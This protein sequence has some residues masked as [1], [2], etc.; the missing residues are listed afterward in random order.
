MR[1][2]EL[3][4]GDRATVLDDCWPV[5]DAGARGAEGIHDGSRELNPDEFAY[6]V[7]AVPGTATEM[8]VPLRVRVGAVVRGRFEDP[9]LQERLEL[10]LNGR[11]DSSFD[12]GILGSGRADVGRG[13]QQALEGRAA[14]DVGERVVGHASTDS[15]EDE[16]APTRVRVPDLRALRLVPGLLLRSPTA[17]DWALASCDRRDRHGGSSSAVAWA[18]AHDPEVGVDRALGLVPA[19]VLAQTIRRLRGA[20]LKEPLE[21][22]VGL[23]RGSEAR[24]ACELVSE[25]RGRMLY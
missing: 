17:L 22:G 1:G 8:E 13:D 23:V 24:V 5:G 3:C 16:S 2:D 12:R 20:S 19:A 4:F 10:G 9:R 11:E 18:L 7:L 25:R 14:Q 15:G 6:P 21:M